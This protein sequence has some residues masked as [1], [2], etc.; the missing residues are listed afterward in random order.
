MTH[1]EFI[2]LV[3]QNPI[4]DTILARLPDVGLPDTW[5]VSSSLPQTIWNME[6]GHLPTRG[7]KDYDVFYFDD[8][9]LSWAAE[10]AVIQQCARAFK[11]LDAE[12]EVRNQ[13]RVHLW[14]P[15]HFGFEGYAP[16]KS[17]RDGI[18]RFLGCCHT[19]GV[20]PDLDGGIRVHAPFGFEDLQARIL[21]PNP[22]ALGPVHT[23]EEKAARWKRS[24][25]DLEV[26][27]PSPEWPI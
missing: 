9:D 18:D 22:K 17:S 14:F 20:G 4:I 8:A 7:I 10:D 11:D 12:I 25:P 19:L 15:Q 27:P 5:I 26:L 13:A 24:W 16:L 23:Y 1:A 2:A 3:R 21:R 6:D